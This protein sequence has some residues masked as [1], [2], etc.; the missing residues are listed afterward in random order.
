M[1]RDATRSPP[2]ADWLDTLRSLGPGGTPAVV[3]TVADAQGS[4]PREAGTKMVVTRDRQFGTIGGGNLEFRATEIARDLIGAGGAHAAGNTLRYFPLGPALGQCCGGAAT[5]GF[6]FVPAPPPAWIG[7]LARIL[8]REPCVTVSATGSDVTPDS[9]LLVTRAAVSGDVGVRDLEVDVTA[10]ARALLAPE[11]AGPGVRLERRPAAAGRESKEGPSL[12]FERHGGC[13]FQI[14]LF[15]AGHVGS[16]VIAV[17]AGLP[18]RIDWVDDRPE[19]FPSVCPANV[20]VEVADAPVYAVDRFPAGAYYLIMTHSHD[21]DCA[22]VERVLGRG[23][24]RYLGLIGSK[25]KRRRFEKR[26]LRRGV[27]RA[28]LERLVCPIGIDGIEGKHPAAIAIAT[29]AEILRLRSA[30]GRAAPEPV[31]AAAK[32]V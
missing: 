2:V 32:P 23:D 28:R 16:A 9:K 27:T 17:L 26:L 13:D 7:E 10:I 5:L 31:A 24:F 8:E 18:C 15:G 11:S 22:L 29:A 19:R 6:E 3:V 21:L 12:L 20:V 4:T 25:S 14:V 1:R 30:A